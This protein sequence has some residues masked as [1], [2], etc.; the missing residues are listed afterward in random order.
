MKKLSAAFLVASLSIGIIPNSNA[1][2]ELVASFPNAGSILSVSPKEVNLIFGE[3]L[4]VFKEKDVNSISLMMLPNQKIRTSPA[5]VKGSKI[6][7]KVL[8]ILGNGDYEVRFR[9]VSADGH[10]LKNSFKFRVK[11]QRTK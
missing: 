8:D 1:H 5:I 3:D 4:T 10:I 6:K 9:V 7:I 11:I 2:A